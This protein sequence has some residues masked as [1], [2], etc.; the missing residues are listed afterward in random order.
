MAIKLILI[1]ITGKSIKVEF[2]S[3]IGWMDGYVPFL[4]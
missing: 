1:I 4:M 3:S 2:Y